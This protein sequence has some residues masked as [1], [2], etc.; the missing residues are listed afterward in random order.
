MYITVS[1]YI[2][3][4]GGFSP[5][6]RYKTWAKFIEVFQQ[7]SMAGNMMVVFTRLKPARLKCYV[8]T[9]FITVLY[10]GWVVLV[11]LC[12]CCCC[13]CCCCCCTSAG[14]PEAVGG[15]QYFLNYFSQFCS[16]FLSNK[17]RR[18]N[19]RPSKCRLKSSI[20]TLSVLS[21]DV[22]FY[23]FGWE[24]DTEVLVR[25]EFSQCFK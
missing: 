20:F 16:V 5:A 6:D 24:Q 18:F 10:N 12:G 2:I 8:R 3:I 13:C 11:L 21:S 22:L 7:E 17:F 14:T 15:S 9:L 25:V 1:V 23:Q 19:W 4:Y